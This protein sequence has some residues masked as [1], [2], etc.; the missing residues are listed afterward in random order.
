MFTWRL[1]L[2]ILGDSFILLRGEAGMSM[3]VLKGVFIIPECVNQTSGLALPKRSFLFQPAWV[4]FCSS[5]P[6]KRASSRRLCC[7]VP[8]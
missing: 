3:A 7:P 6:G 2:Q 5:Q 4:E 8:L 1:L